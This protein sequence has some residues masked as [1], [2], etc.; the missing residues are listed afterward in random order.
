MKELSLDRYAPP[1]WLN[2]SRLQSGLPISTKLGDINQSTKGK[3]K[4]VS[5]GG[6]IKI[7]HHGDDDKLAVKSFR[8]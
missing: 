8:K 4:Q 3:I 2:E 5:T 6:K 7:V 1:S